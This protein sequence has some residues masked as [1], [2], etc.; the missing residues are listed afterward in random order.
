MIQE[1]ITDHALNEMENPVLGPFNEALY[2]YLALPVFSPDKPQGEVMRLKFLI[3]SSSINERLSMQINDEDGERIA[4]M[5]SD[6]AF[7]LRVQPSGIP[8]EDDE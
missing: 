4:R 7:G 6:P 1:S 5:M 2:N 8:S 3:D